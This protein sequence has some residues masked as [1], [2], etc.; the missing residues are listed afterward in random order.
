MPRAGFAPTVVRTSSDVRADLTDRVVRWE[1]KETFRNTGGQLGE[2]DY[3]FPLPRDAAFEN[4]RLSINGELVAGETLGAQ[5]A[6]SLYEE[7]VRRRRDPALVEWMGYGLLRARIFP[8]APGEEKTVVVRFQTVM[9]RE[10]DAMRIDYVRAGGRSDRTDSTDS[11]RWNFA[12]ALPAQGRYGTP[13][14]PTHQ[15]TTAD[16]D[17]RRVVHVA[18]AARDITILL[19]VEQPARASIAMLPYAPGGEDGYALLTLTPPRAH[20]ANIAPRDVT[21]VLDVSGSMNGRKMDQARAAGRALLKTL[22]PTDRFRL[23]DF[24]T[25]VR[26]FRDGWT[27]ATD[28]NL[29]A[30]DRY[31][32]QLEAEGSTNIRGGAARGVHRGS[33]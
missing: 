5:E 4:L 11:G 24:S 7:I 15:L 28:D 29:A 21:L 30:A 3:L 27:V 1:V 12:L 9:Q 6:R 22:R 14:S 19:P 2:A 13:Y 8:L 17:G 25:D 33:G 20:R 31:F 18:G 16:E 26:S 23:I 10:G 32:T